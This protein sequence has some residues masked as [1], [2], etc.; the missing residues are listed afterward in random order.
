[1]IG[2]RCCIGAGTY[3]YTHGAWNS[4]LEGY[5]VKFA[6]VKL[7]NKSWVAACCL[8]LPGVTVRHNSIVAA[9]SIVLEDV[10][11]NSV[12]AGNPAKTIRK[13]VQKRISF[14]DKNRIVF[15]ML[16]EFASLNSATFIKKQDSEA[17]LK[18][19]LARNIPFLSNSFFIYYLAK[20]DKSKVDRYQKKSKHIFISLKPHKNSIDQCKINNIG[21]IDLNTCTYGNLPKKLGKQMIRLMAHYGIT[22]EPCFEI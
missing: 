22:L 14:E 12:V 21:W 5:P 17:I 1:M 18:V 19:N 7:E 15:E 9:K 16:S 13:C 20:L 4:A 3:I 8:L 11:A 10:P 2:N 6:P